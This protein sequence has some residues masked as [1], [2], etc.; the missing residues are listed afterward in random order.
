MDG[1]IS[2]LQDRIQK[3]EFYSL[4]DRFFS[5]LKKKFI[6]NWRFISDNFYG[7]YLLTN[8]TILID[9]TFLGEHKVRETMKVSWYHV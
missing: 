3:R 4:S 6:M 2:L 9:N 5:H 7:I 1:H 8:V